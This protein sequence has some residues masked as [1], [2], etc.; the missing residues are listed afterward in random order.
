[1]DSQ[2]AL[3]ARVTALLQ[4][5]E[6]FYVPI[7]HI[8]KTLVLE[9]HPINLENLTALLKSQSEFKVISS[10]AALSEDASQAQNGSWEQEMQYNM[11]ALGYYDGDRVSLA[12]RQPTADDMKQL[13][14]KHLGHMTAALGKAKEACAPDDTATQQKL[15]ELL[16]ELDAP[17]NKKEPAAQTAN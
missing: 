7:K 10:E 6:E 11:E 3:L 2:A 8:W 1:M 17:G 12:D 5:S 4:G 13:I 15:Q 14:H 16:T 9:G